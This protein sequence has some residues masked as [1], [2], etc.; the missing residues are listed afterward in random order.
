[1]ST[2]VEILRVIGIVSNV[3]DFLGPAGEIISALFFIGT[4]CYAVVERIK[5]LDKFDPDVLTKVKESLGAI[6]G[7]PPSEEFARPLQRIEAYQQQLQDQKKTFSANLDICRIVLPGIH[8][9]P[10]CPKTKYTIGCL[11]PCLIPRNLTTCELYRVETDPDSIVDLSGQYRHPVDKIFLDAKLDP[12]S[13]V[14]G[15]KVFCPPILSEKEGGQAP[16]EKQFLCYGAWGI[17]NTQQHNQSKPCVDIIA[18]GDGN[19]QAHAASNPNHTTYFM[20]GEGKKIFIGTKQ[21]ETVFM[22]SGNHTQGL[23]D[24]SPSDHAT[25]DVTGFAPSIPSIVID[26]PHHQLIDAGASIQITGINT[27]Y[28]RPE[29]QEQITASCDTHNIYGNG[30]TLDHPDRILIPEMGCAQPMAMSIGVS[31]HTEVINQ[32]RQ[33]GSH[34]LYVIAQGAGTVHIQLA[35]PQGAMQVTHHFKFNYP[36]SAVQALHTMPF[37][38]SAGQSKTMVIRVILQENQQQ[39]SLTAMP[40]PS[41]NVSYL[42][43]DGEVWFDPEGRHYGMVKW[44][45]SGPIHRTIDAA[46][47]ISELGIMLRVYVTHPNNDRVN[48]IHISHAWKSAVW[49]ID[50]DQGTTHLLTLHA[51]QDAPLMQNITYTV[52]ASNNHQPFPSITTIEW[53][54]PEGHHQGHYILD[55]SRFIGPWAR[56][57]T[58]Y[59]SIRE[60]NATVELIFGKHNSVMPLLWVKFAEFKHWSNSVRVIIQRAPVEIVWEQDSW[61]LRPEPLV[62]DRNVAIVSIAYEEIALRRVII[63]LRQCRKF[64]WFRDKDDLVAT[65]LRTPV[66]EYAHVLPK[67]KLQPKCTLHIENFYLHPDAYTLTLRAGQHNISLRDIAALKQVP[68]WQDFLAWQISGIDE[69]IIQLTHGNNATLIRSA[70]WLGP[71]DEQPWSDALLSAR[72]DQQTNAAQRPSFFLDTIASWVK[73]RLRYLFLDDQSSDKQ[74]FTAQSAPA[75]TQPTHEIESAGACYWAA[76][77]V[78][79][80]S[81]GIKVRRSH[82]SEHSHIINNM[83]LTVLPDKFIVQSNSMQNSTLIEHAVFSQDPLQLEMTLSGHAPHKIPL[84][85]TEVPIATLLAQ[86]PTTVVNAWQETA[87]KKLGR[88]YLWQQSRVYFVQQVVGHLFLHTSVGDWF[89]A[90][91]ERCRFDLGDEQYFS[92]CVAHWMSAPSDLRAVVA[93]MLQGVILQR[94]VQNR[95]VCYVGQPM[96]R[97]CQRYQRYLC[98][99]NLVWHEQ[100]MAHHLVR[101]MQILPQLW[102]VDAYHIPTVVLLHCLPQQFPWL[103]VVKMITNLLLQLSVAT[104]IPLPYVLAAYVVPYVFTLTEY[105]GFSL[106]DVFDW[107]ITYCRHFTSSCCQPYLRALQQIFQVF[108]QYALLTQVVH[109]WAEAVA[110][111]PPDQERLNV[112][113]GI[114]REKA[115][116]REKCMMWS[117][118]AKKK[119]LSFVAETRQKASSL[120]DQTTYT[121]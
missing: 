57:Y 120:F 43:R 121:R 96:L 113:N 10:D 17:E 99:K 80:M 3:L 109:G 59:P 84:S 23:L 51:E 34:F 19:D 62:Y 56:K 71:S 107:S 27:V 98:K 117:H 75:P 25:L 85:A 105:F 29:R 18:L 52:R 38:A 61:Q 101:G 89:A 36:L 40:L 93:V 6:F 100:D 14:E 68:E 35:E 76:H 86:L 66:L 4:A 95:Y 104:D 81:C 12:A 50:P 33:P 22:L 78:P 69:Q 97:F 82:L 63:W 39:L 108:F 45:R 55:L 74:S 87:N 73:E 42:F 53:H 111:V 47:K 26:L 31:P 24:G 77:K 20:V 58:L 5:L 2:G 65:N 8:L 41:Q 90:W 83:L 13:S 15:V 9:Q 21:Q 112:S 106:I 67:Y 16:S 115:I 49:E 28:G 37:N 1:M 64:A 110:A 46:R 79:V 30:G 32:H 54:R 103:N 48:V 114:K 92:S 72:Q 60:R 94:G 119:M 70:P 7:L 44:E 11:W 116:R 88:R 118:G 91:G 102:Q